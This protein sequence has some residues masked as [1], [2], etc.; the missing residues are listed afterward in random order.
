M[1][2]CPFSK[3]DKIEYYNIVLV[4][5]KIV[6]VAMKCANGVPYLTDDLSCKLAMFLKNFIKMT[7]SYQ[8]E[9]FWSIESCVNFIYTNWIYNWNQN[10]FQTDTYQ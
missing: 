3:W 7:D 9:M 2:S 6:T 10:V 8:F 4:A 5:I 1:T